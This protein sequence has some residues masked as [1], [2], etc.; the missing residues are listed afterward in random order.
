MPQDKKVAAHRPA[1]MVD[2]C[3]TATTNKI[4]DLERCDRLFPIGT[5]ARMVA[6][7]PWAN[8]ILKCSLK[9]VDENDYARPLTD[10]QLASMHRIFSEGVCDWTRSGV[11]QVPL[12]GTWAFYTGDAEVEYLR[13]AR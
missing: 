8:D 10:E 3:F 12:A 2:A 6:G 11:G 13:P 4:T 1:G 7:A 5:D 9:P